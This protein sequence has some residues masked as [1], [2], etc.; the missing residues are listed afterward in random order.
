MS[1]M[2]TK[3]IIFD[4]WNTLLENPKDCRKEIARILNLDGDYV[5]RKFKE[6]NLTY[7]TN[8]DFFKQM[9]KD[10]KI[11]QKIMK[12]WEN[13]NKR[14]ILFYDVKNTLT[15]LKKRNIKLAIL[16]NATPNTFEILKAKRIEC[17][18]DKIYLSYEYQITKPDIKFFKIV[19]KNFK[20]LPKEVIMVG[21]K[22]ESDL[23]PAKKLGIK[24]ILIDR[25]N[26]KEKNISDYKIN[27][28]REI[29]E[30][31]ERYN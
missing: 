8:K 25:K 20:L 12:I 31:I 24:T 14:C 18:F 21:D 1:K 3:L 15:E 19:L 30:I 11:I 26:K 17:F 10:E 5:K 22:E 29:I 6:W 7:L 9:T 23:E 27:D 4:I 2:K 16:S 13:A 28:L